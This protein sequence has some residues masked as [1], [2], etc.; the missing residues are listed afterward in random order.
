MGETITT[1]KDTGNAF[2]LDLGSGVG[3]RN[4]GRFGRRAGHGRGRADLV[5]DAERAGD[6]TSRVFA[7]DLSAAH[8]RMADLGANEGEGP[9]AVSGRKVVG[10][11]AVH[12]R[13]HAA[14]WT[15]FT[16][17]APASTSTSGPPPW[18]RTPRRLPS[19]SRAPVTPLHQ[20]ALATPHEHSDLV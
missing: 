12:G 13:T 20:S 10:A 1:N 8:P 15:L 3:T 11:T 16:S 7:Y 14:A 2:A 18:R 19:L 9:V 5:G 17:G 6:G 4:L